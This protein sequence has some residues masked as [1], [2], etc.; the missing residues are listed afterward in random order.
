MAHGSPDSLAIHI[1]VLSDGP[2]SEALPLLPH[3]LR[4]E[5]VV[6]GSRMLPG[7]VALRPISSHCPAAKRG[8]HT[9]ERGDTWKHGLPADHSTKKPLQVPFQV[10]NDVVG[11]RI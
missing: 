8:S 1:L 4:F 2:I 9:W 5:A 7:P 6:I 11:N 3:P 10:A